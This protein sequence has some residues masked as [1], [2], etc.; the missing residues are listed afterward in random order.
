MKR[1]S[2]G[3]IIMS[4]MLDHFSDLKEKNYWDV[5]AMSEEELYHSFDVL[6]EKMNIIYKFVLGYNDYINMRHNYKADE[7]LTMLEAHILT[8]ICDYEGS[9]VTSLSAAWGRSV[10]AT[11]QTVRQLINKGLVTRENSTENRKIFYLKPTEKG[12]QVSNSHK[13]YDTEDT[14]KTIKRLLK[15]LSFEEIETMF[16]A[17][18]CYA[19]LLRERPKEN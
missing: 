9:T 5:D 18:D 2:S 4:T 10:S 11:S 17:V 15:S 13:R 19:E 3:G 12:I 7:S 14:I 8:D 16:K 1:L 6:N